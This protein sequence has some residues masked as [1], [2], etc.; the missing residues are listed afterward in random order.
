MCGIAG[1]SYFESDRPVDQRVL[2]RMTDVL[3]HRGPD[4]R[5][6]HVDG[7]SGL[8]HRRLAIIDLSAAAAQPLAN[9]DGS[10]LVAVNGEIYNFR[11]LRDEL[12]GRGH[13]FRSRSDSEVL[14][15]MYEE[16]GDRF[17]E[18]LRGMFAFA[19]WDARRRRWLLAR[20]RFGQKPLYY[21][22][23]E[24]TLH[25][26]SEVKAILQD[27]D[28][29]RQADLRSLDAY[30]TYGYVPAPST[31]F[32]GIRKLLPGHLLTVEADGRHELRRYWRL[33][34]SPKEPAAV[35][36]RSRRQAEDRVLG[37]LDESTRLR[38]ISDVPLGALLSGGI[39]SSAVVASMCAARSGDSGSV[40]TFSLGFR[41]PS[42][43]E[44]AY[45]AEVAQHLG[46]DHHRLELTAEAFAGLERIAWHYGEPF[47]DPSC[48]PTFAVTALARRHVTVALTGDGAD[49]LFCGYRRYAAV[50]LEEEVR[51]LPAPL[52]ALARSPTMT[53]LLRRTRRRALAVELDRSRN[54]RGL[55]VAHGYVARLQALDGGLKTRLYDGG[56]AE[57]VDGWNACLPLL[58]AIARS[59]GE[60]LAE[61]CAH[62]DVLTYLPDDIL[63]KVDVASMAHGLECRA[64]LLDHV[65]A[66]YVASLPFGLK[67]RRLNR[68][69]VLK[70]AVADRLPQRTLTRGKRGFN[71]PLRSWFRG[72]LEALL[73]ET[74]LSRRASERGYFTR[75]AVEG[76]ID[77]HGRGVSDH[78]GVLFCLLMLELWHRLWI[79]PSP[80]GSL[81][82]SPPA[83]G[84]ERW[85]AGLE[86]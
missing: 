67:M 4:G 27:P 22:L 15:H 45:A 46:T 70:G 54:C 76:M 20:D 10:V 82:L 26:G 50:R 71:V 3:A 1:I 14:V 66:E 18:R 62:A 85:T 73:R 32:T 39:D 47:A 19:L 86:S 77:E 8:G 78:Q 41:E 40:K 11:E 83:A 81:E 55:A 61:R 48:L 63:V 52:R 2:D 33:R 28:V 74:L 57:R 9:E 37:L 23:T 42:Y 29:P 43:D 21:R 35:T 80:A 53:G 51:A 6:T 38:M 64:P 13:A 56:F 25:F 17:V 34:L 12:V 44:S 49:E 7:S 79:D 36:A 60:A 59:D 5:G 72:S 16:A 65:L 30:L 24:R 69:A 75:S 58:R 31:A 84:G 68:K